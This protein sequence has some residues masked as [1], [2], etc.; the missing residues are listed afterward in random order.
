ME[1]MIEKFKTFK[2]SAEQMKKVNGGAECKYYGQFL[3]CIQGGG[4]PEN[5]N[6]TWCPPE[7]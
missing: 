2:L 3:T 6:R 1:K 5:C 7:E 4:T